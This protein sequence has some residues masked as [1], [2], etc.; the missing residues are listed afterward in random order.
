MELEQRLLEMF[1]AEVPGDYFSGGV[2]GQVV[3]DKRKFTV[4]RGWSDLEV[5]P[6]GFLI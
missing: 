6:Y 1:T 5:R 4:I 3:E 2:F